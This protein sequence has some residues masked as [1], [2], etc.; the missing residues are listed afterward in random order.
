MSGGAK[1]RVIL[2][3]LR[4]SNFLVFIKF[5][6]ISILTPHYLK[7]Y[8]NYTYIHPYKPMD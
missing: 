5:D 4:L 1:T 6:I 3:F 8:Y 7:S 2:M